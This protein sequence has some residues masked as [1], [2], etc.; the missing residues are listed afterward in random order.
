MTT[1][2]SS[3]LIRSGIEPFLTCRGLGKYGLLM[4]VLL[5][6]PTLAHATWPE[7]PIRIVVP[8]VSGGAA[9]SAARLM[10]PSLQKRLGQPVVIE[11]R[12]GAGATIGTASV[13]TASP[14]GY[15]LLMGSA[16]NAIGNAI[17]SKM[18]YVFERDLV[19]VM[20]VAEIPGVVVVPSKLPVKNIQELVA[21]VK[22]HPGEMSYGS[23]GY[24]TSVHLAG[25][26]FQSMTETSMVHV[27][28]K[29][30]SAAMTD[31]LG[32]RLQLMFPALAAAQSHIQAGSLRALAVTTRQRSVIVPDLP[33][34]HEA[35][36]PGYEVGGWIGLFS[37]KGLAPEVMTAL[38]RAIDETMKDEEVR[39]ALFKSGIEPAPA[40]AQVLRGKVESDSRRWEQV[41]KN[42]KMELQ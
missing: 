29:G 30:A 10:A 2:R 18:P 35:G 27:P 24:G 41:I 21:Y 16:S 26:L 5:L 7:K 40:S 36:L 23:P 34:V 1:S 25:E 15:T 4:A 37:P 19:P 9:D 31:L 20:L 38:Q 28:Y 13:A 14:D 11:N 8:F 3:Q 33:T 12:A 22:A 42:R 39:R 6:G 32:M 17:Q